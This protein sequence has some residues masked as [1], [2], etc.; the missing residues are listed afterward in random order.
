M[1]LEGNSP[2]ISKKGIDIM[3]NNKIKLM[4]AY[5]RFLQEGQYIV[6]NKILELLCKKKI[7][8]G[9]DN[10]SWEIEKLAYKFKLRITYSRNYGGA[11]VYL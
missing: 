7:Y 1:K 3:N 9:L 10:N 11:C 5:H 2:L 8:L 6:A 4:F